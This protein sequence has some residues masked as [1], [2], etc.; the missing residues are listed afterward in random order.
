M[1]VSSRRGRGWVSL[2]STHPTQALHPGL[3]SLVIGRRIFAQQHFAGLMAD[4]ELPIVLLEDGG[5]AIER[6]E[7]LRHV[8]VPLRRAMTV[9]I[10]AG[11][12]GVP[13]E[14]HSTGL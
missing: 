13:G 8:E 1:D 6:G 3:A 5:H 11:M 9:P 10:G 2:R 7:G 12:A 14:Q 4:P